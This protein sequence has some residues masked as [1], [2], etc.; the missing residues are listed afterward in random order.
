MIANYNKQHQ[1]PSL[2]L[3][4]RGG[5]LEELVVQRQLGS[6]PA[7]TAYVEE[8]ADEV[9]QTGITDLRTTR[10][11][12]WTFAR[13]DRLARISLTRPHLL[14]M[15]SIKASTSALYKQNIKSTLSKRS[16]QK[17]IILEK[18][19]SKRNEIY[20]DLSS[21]SAFIFRHF[22]MVTTAFLNFQD[23]KLTKKIWCV[24]WCCSPTP[25][26]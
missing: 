20:I 17:H 25:P 6:R 22:Q 15:R 14:K 9:H 23:Q 16:Y 19:G 26:S 21:C 7:V 3:D 18:I 5:F 8:E 12:F 1:G 2:C 24:P 13:V 4:F 11:Q 10:F